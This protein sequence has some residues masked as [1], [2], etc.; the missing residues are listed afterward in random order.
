MKI[1]LTGGSGLLGR[2]LQKY[3][4]CD[5]P[6]HEELDITKTIPEKAYNLI[7]HAAAYT[8]VVKAESD[9]KA[10]AEVNI[11]GTFNLLEAYP[12]TPFVFISSEY[13]Y[14]PVNYYSTTKA[15]GEKLVAML[16]PMFLII[17]TLFKPNPFPWEQAFVDQYTQGDYVDVI[18]PLIAEEINKWEKKISRL[19]YVGTG[20][21]SMH[22]LAKR[23]NP[24]VR[25]CSVD[26]IKDV[27]IPKDYV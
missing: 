22:E 2:E 5:A 15:T 6:T 11:R 10:C 9:K 21:K 12:D 8:D 18:A 27:R 26:D 20:R 25:E 24:N 1:L 19:T 7:I 17:R 14:N 13:A 23:T 16:S 3:F 4:L